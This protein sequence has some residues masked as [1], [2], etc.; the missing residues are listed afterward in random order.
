MVVH[1]S[2]IVTLS[3]ISALSS[4]FPMKRDKSTITTYDYYCKGASERHGPA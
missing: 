4:F 2:L 3:G 1:P